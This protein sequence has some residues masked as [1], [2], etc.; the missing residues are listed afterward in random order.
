MNWSDIGSIVGKAAPVV[1]TLLAGPAGGMVGGLIANALNVSPDPDSVNAALA[2]DPDALLK[3]QELQINAKVQL[4]Q[5]T[6]TAENNRLQ[7]EGAQFA[8]EAADRDSARQ[9]AAKQ[10]N[11]LIR[12]A[13]TIILLV[14]AL[15]ILVCIFT[16]VGLEALQNPVAAS[17]ISLLIGLWFSE[18]KQTLGFY[19]GMTKESQ[20]Q[21]A[22]VTQFAVE[23]GTVMKPDK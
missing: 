19:F 3:V 20:T 16:G 10:P 15:S 11:D 17:T 12:P 9:L 5:L 2:G 1:G 8:A 14:G 18:L 22:I 7:A 23:P 13:I 4:E 6:V 21:N